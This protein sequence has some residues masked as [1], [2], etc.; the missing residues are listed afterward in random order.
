MPEH[1]DAEITAIQT[2][3][4]ALTPLKTEARARVIEYAFR[5][6]GISASPGILEQPSVPRATAADQPIAPGPQDIRSLKDRKQPR[7]ASEMAAL[8][9]YYLLEAAPMGE[10]SN[11]VSAATLDRYFKQARYPLPKAIQMTLPQAASAGYFDQVSRGEYK[12]NPVGYNLVVHGLPPSSES[13]GFRP[14]SRARVSK[15]S[16]KV[17]KQDKK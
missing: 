15:Q 5:R 2:I 13:E 9:A 8:V 11:T 6:L 12:L 10:R 14:K 1:N 7:T 17:R 16:R 3:L 4:G